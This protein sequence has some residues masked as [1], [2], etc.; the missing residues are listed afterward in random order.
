MAVPRHGAVW[1]KLGSDF[2]SLPWQWGKSRWAGQEQG[3]TKVTHTVS[4]W[5]CSLFIR[6]PWPWTVTDALG[7]QVP[8]R[9]QEAA[10]APVRR[11]S[12]PLPT[13]SP[14]KVRLEGLSEELSSALGL[15]QQRQ[16]A[17]GGLPQGPGRIWRWE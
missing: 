15:A 14:P 17:L 10:S 13:R 5:S 1:P 9:P 8:A 16:T 2:Q 12:T 7:L 6:C 4:P 3:W 11:T